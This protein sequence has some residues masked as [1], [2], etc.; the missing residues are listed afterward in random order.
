MQKPPETIALIPEQTKIII[1][2]IKD[3]VT[4]EIHAIAPGSFVCGDRKRIKAKKK[5][6]KH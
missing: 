4:L 2:W 1:N 6:V 3:S 5:S